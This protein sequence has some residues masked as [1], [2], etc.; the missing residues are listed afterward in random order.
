MMRFVKI[1]TDPY[2]L[3]NLSDKILY[4]DCLRVM[5]E[6]SMKLLVDG[7]MAYNRYIEDVTD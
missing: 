4:Q 7:E 2:N 3:A 1:E 5:N 6:H